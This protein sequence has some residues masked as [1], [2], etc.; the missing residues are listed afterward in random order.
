MMCQKVAEMNP[1]NIIN[2]DQMSIVYSYQ[3]NSTISK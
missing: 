1:D 2:M 3:S